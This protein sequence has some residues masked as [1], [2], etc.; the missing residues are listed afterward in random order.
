MGTSPNVNMHLDDATLGVAL[1]ASADLLN[2]V[3]DGQ[4]GIGIGANAD[5]VR[6]IFAR[7]ADSDRKADNSLCI[8]MSSQRWTGIAAGEVAFGAVDTDLCDAS[9]NAT[10]HRTA[11]K[12]NTFDVAAIS[13]DGEQVAT[14]THVSWSPSLNRDAAAMSSRAGREAAAVEL[15]SLNADP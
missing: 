10:V 13:V 12:S 2:G 14:A 6:S 15:A 11:D 5:G 3:A 8:V 4:L 9:Q 1:E 7:I